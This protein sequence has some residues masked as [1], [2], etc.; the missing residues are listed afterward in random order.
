RTVSSEFLLPDGPTAS[1]VVRMRP[2]PRAPHLPVCWSFGICQ[3][4][5]RIEND[6]RLAQTSSDFLQRPADGCGSLEMSAPCDVAGAGLVF[7]LSSTGASK[8]G[9]HDGFRGGR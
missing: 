6:C 3:N 7:A 4:W 2:P 8:G 9:C 1:A 5:S